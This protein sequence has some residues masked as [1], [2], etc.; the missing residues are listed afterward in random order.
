MTGSPTPGSVAAWVAL[1]RAQTATLARIEADLDGAGLPPLAWYDVLLELRRAERASKRLRQR[2]LQAALLLAGYNL[3]RLLDRMAGAGL[4]AREPTPDDR[5]GIDIVPTAE[6][7]AMRRRMWPVYAR[8]LGH[9]VG[10][11]FDAAEATTLATLLE[12]LR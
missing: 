3:S 6:G 8:A 9:H 5:R 4:V 7:R 10:R 2:D 12:R 11:H 1:M